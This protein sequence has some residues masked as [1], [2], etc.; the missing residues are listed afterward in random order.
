MARPKFTPIKFKYFISP[1]EDI[2][3]DSKEL[4]NKLNKLKTVDVCSK[5]IIRCI[6]IIFFLFLLGLQNWYV[7]RLVS[8]AQVQGKLRESQIVFSILTSS[9]LTE[10]YFVIKEIVKWL[11]RDIDYKILND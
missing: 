6:F 7:F 1:T 5:I 10:T 11:V 4:T 2:K 3:E 9:T 8:N